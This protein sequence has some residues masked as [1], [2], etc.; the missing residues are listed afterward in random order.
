VNQGRD[1]HYQR[2]TAVR[3]PVQAYSRPPYVHGGH[4]YYA[5]HPYDYHPYHPYFW[6]AGFQPFGAF[7]ASLAATA[8]LIDIADTQYG[9][10]DGTWYAPVDG[11][12]DVVTAPVGAVIPSLP[13]DAEQV[14]QDTYYYGGAYYQQL[15]DGS[16]RVVTP[17]AGLVVSQL[18]P[19]G[20][21]IEVGDQHYV[22]F[23]STYYQ[24]IIV[25]GQYRYEVV[26]VR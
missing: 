3:P 23:G 11:G 2:N 10:A 20:E 9:Y 19:G 15:S 13:G 14:A 21:E 6:G 8:I 7:F 16:Y 26:E 1:I 12:Y 5:H 25:D 24:P 17:W 18:P 4:R 22:R